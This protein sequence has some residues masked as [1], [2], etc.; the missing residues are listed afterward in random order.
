MRGILPLFSPHDKDKVQCVIESLR[1]SSPDEFPKQSSARADEV[2]WY[3]K[4]NAIDYA[5]HRSRS[6]NAVIRVYDAAGNVI[7]THEHH[8]GGDQ[9]GDDCPQALPSYC[10][11]FGWTHSKAWLPQ[12]IN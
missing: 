5:K 9:P 2:R 8:D 12:N 4:P 3:G 11:G 7:K 6:H 1:L 10:D